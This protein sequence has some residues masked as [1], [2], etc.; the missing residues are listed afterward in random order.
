[1]K[2]WWLLFVPGLAL[3][4]V[5]T[6]KQPFVYMWDW[7]GTVDHFELRLDVGG[8]VNVG[9]PPNVAG[10]YTLQGDSTI[11]GSHSAV[12]RA[13]TTPTGC[14]PDSNTVSF[15]VSTVPTPAPVPGTPAGLKIVAAPIIPPGPVESPSGTMVTT[16][17]GGPIIDSTLTS[18]TFGSKD[19]AVEGGREFVIKRNGQNEGA[20][21]KLCYLNKVVYAFSNTVWYK[22]TTSFSPQATAPAGC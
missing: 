6:V 5:L 2:P 1:M 17:G 22:W 7:T 10:T 8:Y 9:L 3:A 15:T 16:V 21:V 14:G 11:T 13:C 12:V 20:A 19:P 4:Q 18:W